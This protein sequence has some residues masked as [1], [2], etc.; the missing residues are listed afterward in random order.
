MPGFDLLLANL[1]QPIVLAFVLGALAA[2][3]RA[4]W[5]CPRR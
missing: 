4:S 2:S 1:L 3:S 5:N